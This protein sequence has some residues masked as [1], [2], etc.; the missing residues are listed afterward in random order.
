MMS[1]SILSLPPGRRVRTSVALGPYVGGMFCSLE[2]EIQQTVPGTERC[3]AEDH[4]ST[5]KEVTISSLPAH[6]EQQVARTGHLSIFR[7]SMRI[8]RDLAGSLFCLCKFPEIPCGGTVQGLAQKVRRFLQRRRGRTHNNAAPPA[9]ILSRPTPHTHHGHSITSSRGEK[10]RQA[11]MNHGYAARLV[12]R[13]SGRTRTSITFLLRPYFPLSFPSLGYRRVVRSDGR[14]RQRS[15]SWKV[16]MLCEDNVAGI[17]SPEFYPSPHGE[18]SNSRVYC[19]FL[20]DLLA[21]R[22]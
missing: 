6:G 22:A 9:E 5:R 7:A 14:P 1:P 20:L 16:A 4:L 18:M 13:P 19:K 11:P 2:L 10:D 12:P 17:C 3:V 8:L 21:Y 15:V